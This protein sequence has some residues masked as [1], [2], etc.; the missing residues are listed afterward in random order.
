LGQEKSGQVTDPAQRK[1]DMLTTISGS[2]P[3]SEAGRGPVIH[4]E[5]LGQEKS[6][7][8]TDPAQRKADML[9]TIS[10][11]PPQS[12][13][14]Q[15]P[16]IHGKRLG[17]EKSGQVTD[18]AQRKPD[19]LTTISGSPP[20]SEAGQG[21]VIHGKRLGQE[22][23][24][25][26]TDPAQRK[27]DMLT[28]ISKNLNPANA[29][30]TCT[31]KNVPACTR[32]KRNQD[33]VELKKS[34]NH[35][36]VKSVLVTY[37]RK[38]KLMRNEQRLFYVC[39]DC[40]SQ[41]T[42]VMEDSISTSNVSCTPQPQY[43][44]SRDSVTRPAMVQQSNV[45]DDFKSSSDAANYVIDL[46]NQ[47]KFSAKQLA[48]IL[49]AIGRKVRKE[50]KAET[51]TTVKH[52]DT[53]NGFQLYSDLWKSDNFGLHKAYLRG[54]CN[55]RL[56]NEMFSNILIHFHTKKSYNSTKKSSTCLR[57]IFSAMMSTGRKKSSAA[58]SKALI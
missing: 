58:S 53:I 34:T 35:R 1:A 26:V 40:M 50:F 2:P 36:E 52:R 23:S 6:G 16:V 30:K 11:S 7:Q 10:G 57:Y 55:P 37:M 45:A 54:I 22:K 13:A 19:M 41:L 44:K 18:P 46:I 3:Q 32:C 29:V 24:G 8:V 25:Q 51:S 27:A 47:D 4:G 56:V 48:D 5:R 43:P 14:G 15:G 42:M 49:E 31:S 28:T 33:E 20:Q 12:E 21:P 9:T 38:A 17:Q 39:V